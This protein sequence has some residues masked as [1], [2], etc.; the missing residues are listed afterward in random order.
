MLICFM[1]FV[2]ICFYLFIYFCDMSYCVSLVFTLVF[3]MISLFF[4]RF[5][6]FM[7]YS[8]LK[9][10]H[11]FFL[12]L[13]RLIFSVLHVF[14]L[15]LFLVFFIIN[16]NDCSNIVFLFLMFFLV[17]LPHI[18]LDCIVQVRKKK[19]KIRS[20]PRYLG[21]NFFD[22][23]FLYFCLKKKHAEMGS[24]RGTSGEP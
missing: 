17:L 11:C 16:D 20:R 13:F 10:F 1:F 5:S 2:L 7:F 24:A 21:P 3:F 18:L 12:F 19:V 23:V 6:F 4:D 15:V 9:G 14:V 8:C 22:A